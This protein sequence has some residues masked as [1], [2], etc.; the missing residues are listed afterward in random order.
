MFVFVNHFAVIGLSCG[1]GLVFAGGELWHCR[2]R[3]TQPV[4]STLYDSKPLVEFGDIHVDHFLVM[5]MLASNIDKFFH[6][7][8][9]D[10]G[11]IELV[12]LSEGLVFDGN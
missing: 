6:K 3:R 11:D 2:F 7:L 10:G 9:S 8:S 4:K 5:N 1:L 12:N